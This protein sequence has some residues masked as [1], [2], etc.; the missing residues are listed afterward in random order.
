MG[1]RERVKR[2]GGRE[3]GDVKGREKGGGLMVE[4]GKG[5]RG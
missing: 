1:K 5:E 3:K 2:V 4:K